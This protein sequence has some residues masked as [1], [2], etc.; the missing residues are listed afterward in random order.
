MKKM[1]V[2]FT[3]IFSVITAFQQVHKHAFVVP[4]NW[5]KP[6]FDFKKQPLIHSQ[7]LL[8]RVLFYDPLLSRNNTVSCA[9]CHSQYTAFTHVDH[10]LSHGIDDRIG[11]RNSPTLMNMAWSTSFMWD[12]SMP[13]LQQQVF[14]PITH[15]LEMDENV[16]RLSSKLQRTSLY[17]ELFYNAFQDSIITPKNIAIAL[18]QFM[19]TLVS[20]QSKYDRAMAKQEVFTAQEEK[21]YQLF[22]K[23]C[24]S[25]HNEP[26]FTNHGF[27]QNSLAPDSLLN[28]SGRSKV[29][30]RKEDAFKF[31][32][33]TLRNIEFSY[34]YMHDGRFTTLSEVLNHYSVS[35]Q[36]A[37]GP[38][39]I[40]SKDKVDLMAFLLTLTDRKFLFD[41]NHA[42][43][44][45]ILLT[46]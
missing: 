15:P 38:I 44:R 31:K 1:L 8:G 11:T 45:H 4:H 34:P 16:H 14:S 27:E 28:D 33:P 29:T 22:R 46:Q 23:N 24:A 12:G 37:T 13:S 20:A 5:P 3:A 41:T 26:L 32:V 21:G 43:P 7:V 19:L 39:I 6:V 42:F 36:S 18:E 10:A 17:P 40:T 9:S 25:C 2:C 30:H 35:F